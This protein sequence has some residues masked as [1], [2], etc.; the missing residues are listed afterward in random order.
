MA[1]WAS[2]GDFT[3]RAAGL[4]WRLVQTLRSSQVSL[5]RPTSMELVRTWPEWPPG[6][7]S[8][9]ST[10]RLEKGPAEEKLEKLRTEN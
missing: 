2:L 8:R 9:H 1:H 4:M 5:L 3:W 6:L 10:A 7:G